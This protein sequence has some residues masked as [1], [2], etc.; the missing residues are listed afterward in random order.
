MSTSLPRSHVVHVDVDGKSYS[1][2]YT[3]QG[4]IVTVSDGQRERSRQLGGIAAEA[5][6]MNLLREM[7]KESAAS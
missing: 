5:L 2:S 3:V 1:G 4:R 7:A 6:A